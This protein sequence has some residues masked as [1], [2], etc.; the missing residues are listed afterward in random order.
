MSNSAST[1]VKSKPTFSYARA[2]QGSS[3]ASTPGAMSPVLNGK[4]IAASSKD[5]SI[6]PNGTSASPIDKSESSL[7][8]AAPQQSRPTHSSRSSVSSAAGTQPAW[9]NKGPGVHMPPRTTQSA[10]TAG[11]S[12]TNLSAGVGAGA[13]QFGN[14]NAANVP[15]QKSPAVETAS[16]P[17]ASGGAA[18]PALQV[19]EAPQFGSITPGTSL[20]ES[21]SSTSPLLSLF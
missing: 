10:A 17:V 11:L 21:V 2:A 7:G 1:D 18:P 12:N 8:S 16:L 3:T 14:F 13:V 4:P 6:A 15:P 5:V 19:K 9:V 20:S